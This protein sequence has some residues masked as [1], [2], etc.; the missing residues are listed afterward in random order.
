MTRICFDSIIYDSLGLF[1]WVP[2]GGAVYW[3]GCTSE[4]DLIAAY[5]EGSGYLASLFSLWG[6][7]HE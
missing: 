7:V 1:D 6:V 5:Y 4:I 3:F 2:S